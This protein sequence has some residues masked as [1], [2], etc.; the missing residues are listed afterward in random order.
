MFLVKAAI[1]IRTSFQAQ[2]GEMGQGA[3]IAIEVL[4]HRCGSPSSYVVE[5]FLYPA[6]K[7]PGCLAHVSRSALAAP[8]AVHRVGVLAGEAV[9][10]AENGSGGADTPFGAGVLAC[11]AAAFRKARPPMLPRL[12]GETKHLADGL[13]DLRSGVALCSPTRKN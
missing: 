11:G 12:A 2:K 4:A 6:S 7:G 9:Q 3:G 8:Y 1:L 5:V 13:P 10:D